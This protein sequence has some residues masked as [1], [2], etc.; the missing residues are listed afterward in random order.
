MQLEVAA[1][2]RRRPSPN[3]RRLDQMTHR[4]IRRHQLVQSSQ[5]S[6]C[7][8]GPSFLVTSSPSIRW[9]GTLDA[10]AGAIDGAHFSAALLLTDDIAHA[11]YNNKLTGRFN[12]KRTVTPRGRDPIS[13]DS[14]LL[15]PTQ[16]LRLVMRVAMEIGIVAALAL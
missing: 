5:H 1:E 12:I 9:L 10:I 13:S 6:L 4:L 7:H 8:A 2:L 16:T 11:I 14:T 3:A 15:S